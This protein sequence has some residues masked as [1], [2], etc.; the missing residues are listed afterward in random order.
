MNRQEIR[1]YIFLTLAK[2]YEDP[3]HRKQYKSFT[4]EK[5]DEQ[6]VQEIF[7]EL[8]HNFIVDQIQPNVV[9]LTEFGYKIIQPDLAELRAKAAGKP[10]VATKVENKYQPPTPEEIEKISNVLQQPDYISVSRLLEG[11]S[12]IFWATDGFKKV[13]GYSLKELKKA[14]GSF[15]LVRGSENLEKLERI[16]TD[17]L[18]G[19][20][21]SD[22]FVIRTKDGD[23]RT[24]RFVARPRFNDEGYVIGTITAVKD[25]T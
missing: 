22:E 25:V 8:T 4:F 9:R 23:H 17:L 14:G 12:E 2:L 3:Y 10:G 19:N 7:S 21:V 24:V 6:V 20:N 1:A 15:A 5:A 18:N 16:G 13:T 11:R